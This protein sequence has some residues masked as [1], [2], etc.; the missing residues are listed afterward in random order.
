MAVGKN[1]KLGKKGKSGKK[2]IDPFLRKEWY[3]IKAPAVFSVRDVGKT[4]VT[5]T[6]GLKIASESLKG[7]VFETN[8]ADLTANEEDGHRK[9][10]LKC[11]EV[12]GTNVLTSFYGMDLVRH[13]MG[14]MIKKW[15]SLIEAHVD[16][17]TT[18]GY[19]LRVFCIAFTKKKQNQVK[20]T[21]YAKTNQAKKIRAK[22][23]QI[24]KAQVGQSNIRQLTLKLIPEVI[25]KEIEK[26][27]NAI[28]PVQN[29]LI[30]KVKLLSAP[31]FDLA[32]L[33][34]AHET[35]A[36]ELGAKVDRIDPAVAPTQLLGAGGRL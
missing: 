21:C 35:S 19:T 22:M 14:A 32:R 7:R 8:L 29:C 13:K 6:T 30:R 17:K 24:I 20:K 9:I 25:G 3:G 1:K 28:F 26:S 27:C 15:Q 4:L 18:D 12:E 34:E 31:K 33:M 23:V 5:K 2:Q 10:K 36:E 16:V 11:E